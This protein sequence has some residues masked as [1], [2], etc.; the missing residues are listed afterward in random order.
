MAQNKQIVRCGACNEEYD[1]KTEDY[2]CPHMSPEKLMTT[3]L[4][5]RERTTLQAITE[6]ARAAEAKVWEW[7]NEPC[8]NSKHSPPILR[9]KR[10]CPECWKELPQVSKQ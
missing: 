10:E 6:I 1:I 5:P 8:S 2:Q 4:A 3:W 7:G 9:K